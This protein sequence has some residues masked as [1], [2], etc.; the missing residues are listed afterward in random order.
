MQQENRD[1]TDAELV[2]LTLQSPEYF[3]ALVERYEKKL[4]RYVRRFSGL[5]MESAEDALQEAFIKIYS[6]LNGYNKDLSFSSWAYR[7]THNET[8]SYLRKNAKIKTVAIESDSE[9]EASLIEVLKSDEDIEID[10][11]KKEL[12]EKVRKAIGL[13][14]EKYRDVLI[15]KYLQDLDYKDISDILKIPMGTVATLVNRAKKKFK[16]IAIQNN[17]NNLN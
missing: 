10:Y 5:D 15:L 1:K 16:E 3:E 13:V 4:L 12:G 2:V 11:S 6:N 7:V 14:P 17:L 8:V 9:D